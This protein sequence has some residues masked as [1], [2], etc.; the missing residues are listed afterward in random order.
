MGALTGA[1]VTNQ[2]SGLLSAVLLMRQRQMFKLSLTIQIH[3]EHI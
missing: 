3:P 1:L 2:N